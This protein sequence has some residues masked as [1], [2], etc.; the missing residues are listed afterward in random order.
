M[1]GPARRGYVAARPAGANVVQRYYLDIAFLAVA[2]FLVW[3][4]SARDAVFTRD[5]VGGLATDPLV[6]IAPALVGLVAVILVLRLLPVGLRALA[7]LGRDRLAMP[8]AA[9]LR[10]AVRNPGPLARLSL[11]L[12]LAAALGTFAASYG[13][14]VVRSFEER[15]RYAAGADLRSPIEPAAP[16]VLQERLD[17]LPGDSPTALAIP[18]HGQHLPHRR[19]HERQRADA[20]PRESARGRLSVV[21]RRLHGDAAG[22]D[23]VRPRPGAL[24]RRHRRAGTTWR[25]SASP[26]T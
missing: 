3:A 10:Q 15:E 13:G 4:V 1:C 11:L 23:P 22:G 9:G 17:G 8:I 5:T 16:G 20:G 24:P 19:R 7:W 14:T 6:L 26:C 18:A 25:S 2:G 21:P 12:L